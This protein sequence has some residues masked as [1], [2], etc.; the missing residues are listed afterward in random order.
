MTFEQSGSNARACFMS[1]TNLNGKPSEKVTVVNIFGGLRKI[2]CFLYLFYINHAVGVG[3][4][5]SASIS[6][7]RIVILKGRSINAD[8]EREGEHYLLMCIY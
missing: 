5:A 3:G 7:E 4:W 8:G 2:F 1:Y 6:H